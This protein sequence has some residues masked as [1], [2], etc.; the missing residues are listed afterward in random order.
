MR[1]PFSSASHK[2]R[3]KEHL[4]LSDK[5]LAAMG[6]SDSPVLESRHDPHLARDIEAAN[7]HDNTQILEN[8]AATNCESL[9]HVFSASSIEST[10]GALDLADP[11]RSVSDW[12]Q[13][14]D[15][16]LLWSQ[17]DDEFQWAQRSKPILLHQMDSQH[18]HEVRPCSISPS[19]PCRAVNEDLTKNH[20]CL[21]D[22]SGRILCSD[23]CDLSSNSQRDGC[24]DHQAACSVSKRIVT[25]FES[26]SQLQTQPETLALNRTDSAASQ[27]SHQLHIESNRLPA[28]ATDSSTP[29]SEVRNVRFAVLEETTA[30]PISSR[31]PRI[32]SASIL[33]PGSTSGSR[34]LDRS[35]SPSVDRSSSPKPRSPRITERLRNKERL[36]HALYD[37]NDPYYEVKY[38]E[39]KHAL[40]SQYENSIIEHG[41][42]SEKQTAQV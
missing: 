28:F 12:N 23:Q 11:V 42:H 8:P 40:G 31:G 33:K 38:V 34:S 32:Q 25:T 39:E 37:K 13:A 2:E 24:L 35:L 36:R 19:P 9:P 22:S 26:S 20:S 15:Y 41:E 18:Q 1:D 21:V 5:S 7:E 27:S 16:Q 10:P 29:S 14:Q 17:N 6:A 4:S 3:S 30:H